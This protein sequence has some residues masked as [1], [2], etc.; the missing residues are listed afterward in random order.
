MDQI[1]LAMKNGR[2]I[3]WFGFDMLDADQSII[4]DCAEPLRP[5][6]MLAADTPV[7]EAA[8]AFAGDAPHIYFILNE[9]R[10]D[11]WLGYGD[12]YQLPFR[13]CL[14]ALLLGIEQLASDL[15]KTQP[16][17]SLG[18]LSINRLQKVKLTYQNRG[19]RL[20][21]NG[22]EY[23]SILLDCTTFVV[24]YALRFVLP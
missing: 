14:F 24:T 4:G 23:E 20:D 7:I 12:L 17:G 18:A 11:G 15:A 2:V 22:N 13:L 6:G 10:I 9:N 21:R 16:H 8:K 3:G 5:D 1:A 19:L